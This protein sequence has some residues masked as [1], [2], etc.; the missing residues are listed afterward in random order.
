[1]AKVSGRA[2]LVYVSGNEI[3]YANAWSINVDQGVVQGAHFAQTWMDSD[4]GILSWT[5]NI[6]AWHDD[7]TKYL[8]GPATAG[9]TATVVCY[10]KRTDLTKYWSGTALFSGWAC[11]GAMDGYVKESADFS[12]SGSLTRTP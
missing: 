9:T 10:P 6:S 2:G 1:M 7:S 11:D 5:G 12:G 8:Y 4:A 3:P